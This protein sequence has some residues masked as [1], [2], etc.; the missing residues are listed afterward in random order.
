MKASLAQSYAARL[1]LKAYA[2]AQTQYPIAQTQ[3]PIAQ[4]RSPIA[5]FHVSSAGSVPNRADSIPNRADSVLNRAS[6]VLNR[7]DSTHFAISIHFRPLRYS[8]KQIAYGWVFGRVCVVVGRLNVVGWLGLRGCLVGAGVRMMTVGGVVGRLFVCLFVCFS[9]RGCGVAWMTHAR[10]ITKSLVSTSSSAAAAAF[11]QPPVAGHSR[12]RPAATRCWTFP[13]PYSYQQPISRRP[14]TDTRRWTFPATVF[15]SRSLPIS[16]S[17][18]ESYQQ[19]P[20]VG[21]FPP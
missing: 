11:R 9:V 13:P 21:H 17:P 3:Y 15:S 8:S 18:L 4:T 16:R 6:S 20:V 12:H 1:F 5:P 14:S 10:V 19:T 2:L 7:A